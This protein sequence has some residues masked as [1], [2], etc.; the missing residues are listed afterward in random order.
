MNTAIRFKDCITS[1][2]ILIAS[3]LFIAPLAPIVHADYDF[4]NP[5]YAVHNTPD[6][7]TA[8]GAAEAREDA[9]A[10][11][12]Q[13][14]NDA[15]ERRQAEIRER[16]DHQA[17][18]DRINA[19]QQM[20]EERRTHP[21]TWTSHEVVMDKNG[22]QFDYAEFMR[23]HPNAVDHGS[24]V[25]VT[26]PRHYNYY[27][28]RGAVFAFFALLSLGG[29]LI[30]KA[31][32]WRESRLYA[33]EPDRDVRAAERGTQLAA[34]M[35]GTDVPITMR[36]AALIKPIPHAADK[37][38]EFVR[39]L[40][41]AEAAAPV[42]PPAP[43]VAPPS[44][45]TLWAQTQLD[46]FA[47]DQSPVP[48][49]YASQVK[50]INLDYSAAS[51]ERLDAFIQQL[52]LKTNPVQKDYSERFQHRNLLIL[53]GLYLGT[54]VAR[55]TSQPLKWYD[56]AG[57]KT[58]LDRKGYSESIQCAYS[59]ML[60]RTDHYMPIELLYDMLF[61]DNPSKTC[62][63]SLAHHQQRATIA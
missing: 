58:L 41:G 2:L 15:Y 4:N 40:F 30:S 61:G 36:K 23:T 55:L 49:L 21:D 56:Y 62:V 24:Y 12:Q 33:P 48:I 45:T 50:K 7:S 37:P 46:L 16:N 3:A 6:T 39:P 34:A 9:A 57:A 5:A 59:C 63:A 38:I 32:D 31:K 20:S 22:N 1:R 25:T 42:T 13:E 60:G 28:P 19:E 52:K 43:K 54:T 17:E 51:L 26:E 44:G 8:A 29:W 18:L 47:S 10:A 53:L 27:S 35:A 14:Y 11:R